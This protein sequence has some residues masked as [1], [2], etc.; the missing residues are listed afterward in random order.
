MAVYHFRQNLKAKDLKGDTEKR[1]SELFKATKGFYNEMIRES[2]KDGIQARYDLNSSV[3]K[4]SP[5]FKKLGQ[6]ISRSVI[7]NFNINF[8]NYRKNMNKDASY[9]T[10]KYRTNRSEFFIAFFGSMFSINQKTGQLYIR[11]ESGIISFDISKKFFAKIKKFK[12]VRLHKAQESYYL[13]FEYIKE[14]KPMQYT[15]Y[16]VQRSAGLDLGVDALITVYAEYA[17]PLIISGKQL[18]FMNYKHK[19]MIE[20]AK[21]Q[22]EKNMINEKRIQKEK[23]MFNVACSRLFAYLN[24][25]KVDTLYV[26][27]FSGVKENGPTARNFFMISY[28]LL[29][30]KM[31]DYAKKNGVKI[32]FIEESYT[33]K[34]SFFDREKPYFRNHYIGQRVERGRFRTGFG[35]KL[36]A[37][38]NGAAQ[39]LAKRVDV[40]NR[41]NVMW[42][43]FFID[44]VDENTKLRRQW[45]EALGK[46]YKTKKKINSCML[47]IKDPKTHVLTYSCGYNTT[48]LECLYDKVFYDKDLKKVIIESKENVRRFKEFAKI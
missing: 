10:P 5:N 45:R 37:D 39:I 2:K 1:I 22:N 13:V 7:G 28:Y 35:V 4:R 9:L 34:T 27:D 43:P 15:K 18:K 26:G 21:S 41:D 38:I 14:N 30:R 8:D 32:F 46:I 48:S 19:K 24:Y 12:M 40:V 23:A 17:K 36:H 20:K 6:Q 16:T 42:K 11:T 3:C 47:E 44:L 31:K 29:K 25:A 33:S